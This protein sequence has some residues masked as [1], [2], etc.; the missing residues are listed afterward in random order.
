MPF[1]AD[2]PAPIRWNEPE[3]AKVARRLNAEFG[4]YLDATYGPG[5]TPSDGPR[6]D[7]GDERMPA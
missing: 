4:A 1:D 3:F 7:D 5:G 6:L 2:K